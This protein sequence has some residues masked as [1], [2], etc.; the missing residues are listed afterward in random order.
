[1]GLLYSIEGFFLVLKIIASV[2][3]TVGIVFK[4]DS[5]QM[6]S[7]FSECYKDTELSWSLASAMVKVE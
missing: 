3:F 6:S 5:K 4:T 2:N 7:A 1:M